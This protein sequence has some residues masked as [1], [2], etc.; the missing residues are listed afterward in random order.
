MNQIFEA[1]LLSTNE[2]TDFD[3]MAGTAAS[4]WGQRYRKLEG[5][6]EYGFAHQLNLPSA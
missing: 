4:M 6:Q 2:Y 3:N 1:G 5:A